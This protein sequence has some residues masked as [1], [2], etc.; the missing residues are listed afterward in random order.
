MGLNEVGYE[1]NCQVWATVGNPSSVTSSSSSSSSSP[2]SSY[3][4]TSE[5][6][7]RHPGYIYCPEASG[8]YIILM[9][10]CI[11]GENVKNTC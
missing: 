10:H 7:R 5:D 3:F 11:I 9:L 1:G 8:L 6:Y 4:F 2:P